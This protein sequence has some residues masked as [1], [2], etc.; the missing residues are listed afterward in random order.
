MRQPFIFQKYD[1]R[2]REGEIVTTRDFRDKP[3][4]SIWLEAGGHRG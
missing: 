4:A 1:C 3:P 2:R